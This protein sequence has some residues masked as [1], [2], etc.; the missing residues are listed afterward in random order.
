ISAAR[1]ASGY[2]DGDGPRAPLPSGA[3][4]A[5][6]ARH[7]RRVPAPSLSLRDTGEPGTEQRIEGRDSADRLRGPPG[8]ARW[9]VPGRTRRCA[10]GDGGLEGRVVTPPTVE[11]HDDAAAAAR[12]G[13]SGGGSASGGPWNREVAAPAGPIVARHRRS[14]SSGSIRFARPCVGIGPPRA[15]V[16]FRTADSSMPRR[17]A[18]C[19]IEISPIDP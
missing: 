14:A 11:P 18:Y 5:G 1:L 3:V 9:P 10:R 15:T 7:V 6:R 19:L 2:R 13:A 8:S 12:P 16:R 17:R 4:V